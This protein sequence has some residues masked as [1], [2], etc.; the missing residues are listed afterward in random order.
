MNACEQV[1]KFCLLLNLA[2][3]RAHMRGQ[4]DDYA[5]DARNIGPSKSKGRKA[6]K[7]TRSRGMGSIEMD[8]RVETS[9]LA[10]SVSRG[11]C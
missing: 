5:H 6:E 1:D 7:D 11:V 9:S 8:T 3:V 4:D 10:R 2:R